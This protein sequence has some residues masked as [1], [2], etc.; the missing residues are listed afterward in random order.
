MVVVGY[1]GLRARVQ[2]I[3]AFGPQGEVEEVADKDA[4][5]KLEKWHRMRSR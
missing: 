2:S 5:S 4:S 3:A 1:C